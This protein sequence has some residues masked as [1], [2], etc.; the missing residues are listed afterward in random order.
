MIK[1][2]FKLWII[3]FV[4][5]N[6]LLLIWSLG[7]FRFLEEKIVVQDNIIVIEPDNQ[8]KKFLPP[9]DESFPNEKSKV[10]GAFEDKKKKDQISQRNT[11]LEYKNDK[12]E[13]NNELDIALEKNENKSID[14]DK[15]ELKPSITNQIFEK[16]KSLEEEKLKDNLINNNDQI[17]SKLKNNKNLK[18]NSINKLEAFYVQVASLS[19]KDLVEKEWNRLKKKH[20]KYMTDLIYITQKAELKDNRVFFRLLVGKFISK[21]EAN[22]FCN[23]LS[24][25]KCIVKKNNE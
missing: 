11:E 14:N 7:Y 22:S 17:E 24:I 1:K 3:L 8:F 5:I 13:N 19:K 2:S 6:L 9:E 21:K 10:W 20:S 25:S 4:I 16:K 23:K 15:L 12:I 18:E